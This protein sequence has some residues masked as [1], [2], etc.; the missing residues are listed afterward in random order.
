MTGKRRGRGS[1]ARRRVPFAFRPFFYAFFPFFSNS[2]L[3]ISRRR[4]L[5]LLRRI[6]IAS[7]LRFAPPRARFRSPNEPF[8]DTLTAALRA[9]RATSLSNTYLPPKR[10]Y[11]LSISFDSIASETLSRRRL[12]ENL[13]TKFALTG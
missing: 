1:A 9:L 5:K 3:W 4:Y 12:R 2:F 8:V 7:I 11:L 6:E 10:T 13:R